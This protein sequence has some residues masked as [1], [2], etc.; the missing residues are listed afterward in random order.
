MGVHFQSSTSVT[1]RIISSM[2]SKN[3]SPQEPVSMCSRMQNMT[4][5]ALAPLAIWLNDSRQKEWLVVIRLLNGWEN[6]IDVKIIYLKYSIKNNKSN[7]SFEVRNI[8]V[9]VSCTRIGTRCTH[10][11]LPSSLTWLT[12]FVRAVLH[13]VA[14][15]VF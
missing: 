8:E 3:N 12:L 9:S 15:Y 13:G 7:R 11:T 1:D 2:I 4:K 6:K 10:N 14:L 5:I